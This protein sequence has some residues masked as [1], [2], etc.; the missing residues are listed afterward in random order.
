VVSNAVAPTRRNWE[1]H[2]KYFWKAFFDMTEL[3]SQFPTNWGYGVTFGKFLVS[4]VPRISCC[5]LKTRKEEEGWNEGCPG[6]Q[7]SCPS[8]RTVLKRLF[9]STGFVRIGK[10]WGSSIGLAGRSIVLMNIY[11]QFLAKYVSFRWLTDS[12]KQSCTW[13]GAKS[14]SNTEEIQF[15]FI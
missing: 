4:F 11:T 13:G 12:M 5:R 6:L 9:R 1:T 3:Y 14:C 8:R 10:I 7:V 15:L 2:S